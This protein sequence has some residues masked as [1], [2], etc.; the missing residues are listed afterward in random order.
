MKSAR[1]VLEAVQILNKRAQA[2]ILLRISFTETENS[3]RLTI[4]LEQSTQTMMISLGSLNL[5]RKPSPNASNIAVPSASRA[6]MIGTRS[7]VMMETST[8]SSPPFVGRKID[9]SL[10]GCAHGGRPTNTLN[11]PF[12]SRVKAGDSAEANDTGGRTAR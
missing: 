8:V 10:P 4:L 5:R 6:S 11:A 7:C 2:E 3:Q 12:L 1:V 9:I